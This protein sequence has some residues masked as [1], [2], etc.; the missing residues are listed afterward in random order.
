M[1]VTAVCGRETHSKI[2]FVLAASGKTKAGDVK[3][4][5]SEGKRPGG[6]P[7][8][9]ERGKTRRYVTVQTH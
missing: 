2:N 1:S 5:M 7:G 8:N 9:E 4:A 6:E 3:N